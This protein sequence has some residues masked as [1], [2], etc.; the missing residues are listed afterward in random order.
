MRKPD[1]ETPVKE[2]VEQLVS[3]NYQALIEMSFD[4]ERLNADD[5]AR[6]IKSYPGRLTPPPASAYQNIEVIPFYDG[7]GYSLA[8]YLW[9]DGEQSDQEIDI[10]A[11]RIDDKLH[12]TL[13]DVLVR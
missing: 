7:T 12:F 4:K 13:W 11:N 8:F 6:E 10:L 9:R 1:F 2:F 3:G 5:I